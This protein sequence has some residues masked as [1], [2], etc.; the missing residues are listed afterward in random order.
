VRNVNQ[1][2]GFDTLAVELLNVST[3]PS[4]RK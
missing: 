4:A 2:L 1:Q 3:V